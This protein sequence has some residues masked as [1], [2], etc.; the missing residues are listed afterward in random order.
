MRRS[1]VVT[2]CTINLVA[3]C[4]ALIFVFKPYFFPRKQQVIEPSAPLASPSENPPVS[5]EEAWGN[6]L[7]SRNRNEAFFA[8]S[9]LPQTP[10]TGSR[11]AEYVSE[12]LEPF[13]RVMWGRSYIDQIAAAIGA[14]EP[15]LDYGSDRTQTL[16][17]ASANH[18]MPIPIRDSA[19]RA[20]IG[21]AHRKR[22]QNPDAGP[23]G[24]QAHLAAFL[25]ETDFG[26][27]TSIGGLAV[28]AALFVRNEKIAPVEP[29][30]FERRIQTVLGN[31]DGVNE[32]T[33]CA[34]L[35]TTAQLDVPEVAGLARE[36]VRRPPSEAVQLAGLR[37]LSRNG[38]YGDAA[39]LETVPAPTPAI[40]S[41]LLDTQRILQE[42]PE[43]KSGSW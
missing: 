5:I 10:E 19:L 40:H 7:K 2:L 25:T 31:R 27:D 15:W 32:F 33:L 9:M 30:F 1:T 8:L 41:A 29:A 3:S 22:L 23:S 24:W 35:D 18:V 12:K 6:F 36:I 39:W 38:H 4:I 17:N 21:S 11:L 34:I 20:V 37:A 42:K 16:E 14:S 26:D 43:R 13:P 28:Q